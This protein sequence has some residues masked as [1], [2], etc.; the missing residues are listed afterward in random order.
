MI[1]H[2]NRELF[3]SKVMEGSETF[4]SI[5]MEKV[6]ELGVVAGLQLIWKYI[7]KPNSVINCIIIII[8]MQS[9]L[10]TVINLEVE[11]PDCQQNIV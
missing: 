11:S 4:S 9:D 3:P 6:S 8:I 10:L 5:L 7:I 1:C 2:K